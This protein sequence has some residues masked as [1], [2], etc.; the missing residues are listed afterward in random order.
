MS[1]DSQISK[2]AVEFW[3]PPCGS[4]GSCLRGT[5][6]TQMK[7]SVLPI[8]PSIHSTACL[9]LPPRPQVPPAS[10][11]P[12]AP[13]CGRAHLTFRMRDPGGVGGVAATWGAGR[14]RQSERVSASQPG[15]ACARALPGG[16]PAACRGPGPAVPLRADARRLRCRCEWSPSP[17][18]RAAGS[19]LSGG[20]T[21]SPP[22]GDPSS[23]AAR[24][25]WSPPGHPPAQEWFGPQSHQCLFSVSWSHTDC[26][27]LPLAAPW[28]GPGPSPASS[29]ARPT[30]AQ[31]R[32]LHLHFR[33]VRPNGKAAPTALPRGRFSRWTAPL[34][35][36]GDGGRKRA[37]QSPEDRRRGC[38]RT[39]QGGEV[40]GRGGSGLGKGPAARCRGWA[41]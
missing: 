16:R 32:E 19:E 4:S 39:A 3:E 26:D 20:T 27:A 41:P 9:S 12:S 34:S 38:L 36:P 35:G 10:V 5:G 14:R 1:P 7:L 6:T 24:G 13:G 33:E 2:G 25:P 28:S 21:P 17:L 11:S 40:S 8:H 15:W 22:A 29:P 18:P 31:L 23:P 37:C 30:L